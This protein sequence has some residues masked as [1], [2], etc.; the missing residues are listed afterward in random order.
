MFKKTGIAATKSWSGHIAFKR[1]ICKIFEYFKKYKQIDTRAKQSTKQDIGA[2]YT[3]PKR[4]GLKTSFDSF[5]P[6]LID[7]S[8]KNIWNDPNC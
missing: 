5:E 4:I 3:D 7:E 8:F 6:I 2:R 1:P